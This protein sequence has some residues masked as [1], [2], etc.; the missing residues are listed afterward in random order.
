MHPETVL[1]QHQLVRTTLNMPTRRSSANPVPSLRCFAKTID[2]GV[3]SDETTFGHLVY[4]G[5]FSRRV[6]L[7]KFLSILSAGCGVLIHPALLLHMEKMPLS[8][9]IILSSFGFV[10]IAAPLLVHRITGRYVVRLYHNPKTNFFTTV[11]PGFVFRKRFFTFSRDDVG[12]PPVPSFFTTIMIR[13]GDLKASF[14]I[15][16][17]DFLDERAYMN[18]LGKQ[19]EL[20]IS[21]NS[22]MRKT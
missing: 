14:I 15:H 1:A 2:K 18:L 7:A 4:V 19:F 10:V 3:P 12:G 9:Q 20:M 13:K 22:E 16:P 8:A 6:Y 21:R 5:S 11:S 17:P